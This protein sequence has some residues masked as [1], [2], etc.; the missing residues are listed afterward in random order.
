M[1]VDFDNERGY[2]AI[3]ETKSGFHIVIMGGNGE[4]IAAGEVLIQQGSAED[5]IAA[6]RRIAL[7]NNPIRF[8]YLD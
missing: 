4:P 1:G 6:I 5:A 3:E 2:F 8:N 7:A